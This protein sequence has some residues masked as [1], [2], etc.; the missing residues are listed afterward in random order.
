MTQAQ[1]QASYGDSD[2]DLP[3]DSSL[4]GRVTDGL[5][6]NGLEADVA[7]TDLNMRSQT[8]ACSSDGFYSF[9]I[10]HRDYRVSATFD[11]YVARGRND[12]SYSVKLEAG[13]DSF[14]QDI[15]LWPEARLIGRITNDG[16]GF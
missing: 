14:V 1:R 9:D 6:H 3:Y 10:D 11:G 16:V 7:L 5:T 12:V 2:S 15:E 13:D 4:S 8:A